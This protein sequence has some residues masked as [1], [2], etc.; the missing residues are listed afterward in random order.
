MSV[1]YTTA[2]AEDVMVVDVT[3]AFGEVNSDIVHET[4]TLLL[5]GL[6]GLAA[7]STT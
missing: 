1:I 5:E 4:V 3:L 2:L 6:A 7:A